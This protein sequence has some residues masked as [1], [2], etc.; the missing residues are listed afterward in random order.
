M[1]QIMQK[2]EYEGT[3]PLIAEKLLERYS[4]ESLT[5]MVNDQKE[6]YTIKNP[7]KFDLC[8]FIDSYLHY[9]DYID[10]QLASRTDEAIFMP[11]LYEKIYSI[12]TNSSEL[13]FAGIDQELG[14]NKITF[15]E[16]CIAAAGYLSS[17]IFS[18]YLDYF[19][20]SLD[21]LNDKSKLEKTEFPLYTLKLYL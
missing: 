18:E 20:T 4:E 11:L 13:K 9:N 2:T 14:P 12:R 6:T 8:Y 10:N 5:L 15:F 19:K 21:Y 17:F 7:D 1:T 3:I 16:S